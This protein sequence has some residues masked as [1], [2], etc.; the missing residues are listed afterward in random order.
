MASRTIT[1]MIKASNITAHGSGKQRSMQRLCLTDGVMTLSLCVPSASHATP[2]MIPTQHQL[3]LMQWNN[4][5]WSLPNPV[6]QLLTPPS[7]NINQ[8]KQNNRRAA[9]NKQDAASRHFLWNWVTTHASW[10]RAGPRY[11]LPVVKP[12]VR[13]FDN[14]N[15]VW[16]R[17]NHHQNQRYDP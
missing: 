17:A 16:Q 13:C 2:F 12:H 1:E 11:N 9:S 7:V 15:R 3:T 6:M 8:L 4:D 10:C 5:H 14:F